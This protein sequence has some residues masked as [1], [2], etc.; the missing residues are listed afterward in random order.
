[1]RTNSAA[2]PLALRARLNEAP[3]SYKLQ[4]KGVCVFLHGLHGHS[5]FCTNLWHMSYIANAGYV[6]RALVSRLGPDAPD[7]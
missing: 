5:G 2:V 3:S 4:P 7:G 1:M 6:V